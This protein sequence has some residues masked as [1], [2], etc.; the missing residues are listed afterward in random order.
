MPISEI[1]WGTSR[2]NG[3]AWPVAGLPRA[4][5]EP[6]LVAHGLENRR[7]F[8]GVAPVPTAFARKRVG[9][10]KRKVV[11]EAIEQP[12]DI[13]ALSDMERRFRVH[14]RQRGPGSVLRRRGKY[15]RRSPAQRQGF[16]F[17]RRKQKRIVFGEGH[18]FG[19][20]RFKTRDLAT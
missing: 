18:D 4:A 11:A 16:S 12:S 3:A 9:W 10:P 6:T 2:A 1:V 19:P 20:S 14:R 8:C 5:I 7:Q 15:P 13:G 17:W